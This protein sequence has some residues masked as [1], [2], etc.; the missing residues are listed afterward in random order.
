M[1]NKINIQEIVDALAEKNGITKKDAEA[2]IRSMFDLIE[3]A[4]EKDRYIKVKGLGTFKLIEVEGRESVNVNTGERFRIEGH[5]KISFI[6]DNSLKETINKPFAH[7]DTVVVNDG[8]DLNMDTPSDD[9]DNLDEI[10]EP[11]TVQENDDST[12]VPSTENEQP[13][14]EDSKQLHDNVEEEASNQQDN[15]EEES[16]IKETETKTT[17]EMHDASSP[18]EKPVV[19]PAN[20]EPKPSS[21]KKGEVLKAMKEDEKV[22]HKALYIIISITA[23][24]V[25]AI[26]W[27]AFSMQN[28]Q[29]MMKPNPKIE[30][31]AKPKP[32]PVKPDTT[33]ILKD[34]TATQKSAEEVSEKTQH[35][36][37]GIKYTAD[38]TMDECVLQ[39]GESL[40]E[41]SKKYYGSPNFIRYI[42]LYNKEAIQDPN[43]IHDGI[44]LKIPHLIPA[45]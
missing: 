33:K 24:L 18:T 37:P 5:S 19:T 42:Y 16:D 35:L 4:L 41:I 9:K 12:D 36:K 6:P 39:K 8:V 44:R 29:K 23:I 31:K 25:I 38:R 21:V 13:E 7:F 40:S 22:S 2:F 11:E 34:S 15:V 28:K 27:F 20:D 3:D 43:V 45:E 1:N 32:I 17:E 10:T 14:K 30:Q 26:I